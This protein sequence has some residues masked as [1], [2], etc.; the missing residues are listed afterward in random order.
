MKDPCW[1]GKMS[2]LS[3]EAHVAD[4][5][6]DQSDRHLAEVVSLLT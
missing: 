1:P 3:V 6:G 2:S 5:L 4:R